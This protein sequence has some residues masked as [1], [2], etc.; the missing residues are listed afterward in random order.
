MRQFN[1]RTAAIVALTSSVFGLYS[2]AP[3]AAN[4]SD[5]KSGSSQSSANNAS[6]QGQN[7]A[8]NSDNKN[9][10]AY[11]NDLLV[12]DSCLFDYQNGKVKPY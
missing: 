1:W 4:N 3:A 9:T 2:I 11:N 10:N 8:S 6:N 12:S 7:Q 5:N